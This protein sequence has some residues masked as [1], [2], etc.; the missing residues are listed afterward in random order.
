VPADGPRD[1]PGRSTPRVR[2]GYVREETAAAR[3]D[4]NYGELL[5][6]L[7]V[8]QTG[9]QILFA[10]LLSIAFQERFAR[11]DDYQRYLYLATLACAACAAILLIAPVAVHRV[12]FRQHL[13]DEVVALTARSAAIGLGFLG[14]AMM[15]AV[16]LIADVV[17]GAAMAVALT[18][19]LSI[20]VL[21]A[22][23][24]MPSLRMRAAADQE[25]RG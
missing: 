14:L 15:C 3:L 24:L 17:S 7:R 6:E 20:V 1:A 25:E 12:M 9:V 13:K 8:A 21:V 11:I 18:A 2:A 16:F 19:P 23:Y 5:Q 10:F 22:W 4:R